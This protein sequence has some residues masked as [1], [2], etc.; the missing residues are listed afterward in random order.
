MS[1]EN[2]PDFLGFVGWKHCL[3]QVMLGKEGT[4]QGSPAV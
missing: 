3:K 2:M 1:G 4:E